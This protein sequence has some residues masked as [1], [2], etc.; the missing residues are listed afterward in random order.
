MGAT[1]KIWDAV[2]EHVLS[3][4]APEWERLDD[5]MFWTCYTELSIHAPE[6]ERLQKWETSVVDS[7]FQSTLPN[8]SD[9]QAIEILE[10][11]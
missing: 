4:H 1:K 5:G 2:V 6:W 11:V 8:G 10:D 3:I 9:Q 7:V